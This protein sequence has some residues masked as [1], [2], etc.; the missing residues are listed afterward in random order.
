MLYEESDLRNRLGF[1]GWANVLMLGIDP[2]SL[3][4]MK[5]SGRTR[6]LSGL[7]F[8]QYSGKRQD[9]TEAE[10]WWNAAQ[11]LPSHFVLH[12]A[13][14]VTEFS[15]TALRQGAD[16]RLFQ[17]AVLRFPSYNLFDLADWLEQ[18]P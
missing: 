1:N 5:P 18:G 2:G 6:A 10:V 7:T 11:L 14:G 12:D 9:G 17:K 3:A 16:E 8:A 13:E 4:E 15:I